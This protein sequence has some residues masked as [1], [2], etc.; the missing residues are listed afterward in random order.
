MNVKEIVTEYLKDNG[1]DGL[2]DDEECGCDLKD[3]MPCEGTIGACTRCVPG[4]RGHD[5]TGDADFCIYESAEAAKNS[6]AAPADS[7]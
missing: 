3:L 2:V 1:F 5:P 7:T 6:L 4:Y